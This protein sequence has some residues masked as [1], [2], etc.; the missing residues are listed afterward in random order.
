MRLDATSHHRGILEDAKQWTVAK[1]RTYA[2]VWFTAI[3][4]PWICFTDF[5][6]E[7]DQTRAIGF[8]VLM[9]VFWQLMTVLLGEP[10][11]PI[12]GN[13]P[14]VS[15]IV[16]TVLLAL[17]VAPVAIHLLA[18]V[19]TLVLIAVVEERASV[20]ETVQVLAYATAPVVFLPIPVV[21]LQVAIGLYGS[22]ILVYGL[23][24]VHEI[25]IW[26]ALL[27]GIIPAYLLFG[28][29]F[30]ADDALL[31]LLRGYRII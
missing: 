16:W 3:V 2:M 28:M 30:G 20:S 18:F 23:R 21:A 6:T 10:S 1:A 14:T 24:V 29:G 17:F 9:V 15:L 25:S 8:I 27:A 22:F 11:H 7:R 12:I 5:I 4:A 26:R 19:T 31:E 13:S